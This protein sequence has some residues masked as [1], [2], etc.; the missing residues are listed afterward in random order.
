MWG[1]GS[2]TQGVGETLW[3]ASPHEDKVEAIIDRSVAK[4]LTAPRRPCTQLPLANIHS[5]IK[6]GGT[7]GT[8]PKSPSHWA[9]SWDCKLC[10]AAVT[11]SFPRKCVSPPDPG[12]HSAGK[13]RPHAHSPPALSPQSARRHRA[14]RR[15]EGL[16]SAPHLSSSTILAYL[17]TSAPP[18][19]HLSS[20]RFPT[21]S[22]STRCNAGP[23][24]S[25]RW[26]AGPQGPGTCSHSSFLQRQQGA[27]RSSLSLGPNPHFKQ[28]CPCPGQSQGNSGKGRASLA[29]TKKVEGFMLWVPQPLNLLPPCH[30]NPSPPVTQL[31]DE[32]GFLVRSTMAKNSTSSLGRDSERPHTRG[33]PCLCHCTD[34]NGPHS[35]PGSWGSP[36]GSRTA[37]YLSAQRAP[38][39][40]HQLL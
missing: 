21:S 3:M 32:R 28:T 40:C 6:S 39:K 9:Q 14:E 24:R 18:P 8:D 22:L 37:S 33:C 29:A 1:S 10:T 17:P 19:P 30:G 26:P 27:T 31:K 25:E 2:L 38:W 20:G 35:G 13:L 5:C 11:G 7:K 15:S 34:P 4:P 36:R 12:L 23:G 16:H